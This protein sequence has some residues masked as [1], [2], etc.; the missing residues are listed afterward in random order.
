MAYRIDNH[1]LNTLIIGTV[2]LIPLFNLYSQQENY[3]VEQIPL[4]PE[5]SHISVHCVL[6]DSAGFMWFG[7][8]TGLYRYDGVD[9][10]VF[11]H[12]PYDPMSISSDYIVGIAEEGANTLWVATQEGLDRFDKYAEHFIRIPIGDTL[13]R[14]ML[15]DRKGNI[16]L[17]LA[18][19][20]LIKF[21]KKSEHITRLKY[22]PPHLD[23]VKPSGGLRKLFM[24]SH[25]QLWFLYESTGLGRFNEETEV[26]EGVDQALPCPLGNIF[27]D[28]RGRIWVTSNC[29]LYLFNRDKEVLEQHIYALEDPDRLKSQRVCSILE[30]KSGNLWISTYDGVYNYNQD[31][32]QLFHMQYPETHSNSLP[33][34]TFFTHLFEDDAGTIW[35]FTR[36]GINKLVKD[37]VNFT[38][39]NP[40]PPAS[41]TV[42]GIYLESNDSIVYGSEESYYAYNRKTGIQKKFNLPWTTKMF[43]D[44]HGVF[45]I[46]SAYG[47]FRRIESDSPIPEYIGY[48]PVPGD[49]SS[50]SGLYINRIFE[51]SEGRLW[52]GSRGGFPCYYD[53]EN[54]C[55]IQLVHNPNS[56]A[57]LTIDACISYETG[58]K[59]L[60]AITEGAFKIIPPFKRVSDHAVM[61][62]DVIEF[63]SPIPTQQDIA[64]FYL[65][66]LDSKGSLWLGDRTMGLFK[67][68]EEGNQVKELI[69]YTTREG[70]PS[71]T[72][73]SIQEDNS[74]NLWIGT[75]NGLSKFDP[76]LE[77]FT[78]YYT[79]NGLPTNQ[80]THS[81]AKN[82]NGELF[83]STIAGM[84]SF[85]PDSIQLNT[86][87]PPIKLTGFRVHNQEIIPTEN[88]I[89][90]RSIVF[91]DDVRLQ[92]NQNTLTINF[93]VLNYIQPER[94]QYKY[95]LEG[96]EKDWIFSGQGN[97]VTY[98]NLKSGNYVFRATGSN[99]DGIWNEEGVS[100]GIVINPP[101]WLTW[102][103][104]IIYGLF[105]TSIIL[106]YRRYLL[107]RA[108]LMAD[109]E[110][111]RVKKEKVQEI[112][113]MRSRFFANISHEFRTP[114]TLIL[115]PIEGML[116]KK[117]KETVI[118]IDQLG[119]I[120][121]NAKRLQHLINQLLDISKLETGKIKMR[122]RKG[123]LLNLSERLYNLSF[124]WLRVKISD[125]NMIWLK[126]PDQYILR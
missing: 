75:S 57:R 107:N 102:W 16:W 64:Q 103:A 97:S 83:F 96:L 98:A 17:G 60:W 122:Y 84:I 5:L 87:I 27:E 126:S 119:T 35:N 116:K 42:R 4:V 30:D 22:I 45:W 50:L 3:R 10:K 81:S 74:G 63:V 21:E 18:A 86:Q 124:P 62:T 92:H 79:Q 118:N 68:T 38:V 14:G 71:N 8:N 36:D 67:L 41:N 105:L 20:G 15:D 31:L 44:S 39:I 19:Y 123:I 109:L 47:L 26:F 59:E 85:H 2:L 73:W 46:G 110:L 53:R 1:L 52:I 104:Y 49:S 111:E 40:D 115:G 9:I 13:I 117:A 93:A 125:M 78:N 55:F 34:V 70:L 6:Q 66:H 80:F 28:R 24:D 121:R 114:L 65:S 94:N 112:D 69:L 33:Y 88:S 76:L 90:K 54:D 56:Q 108:Q 82:A 101:P 11:R 89:L 29:G 120:H 37:H 91:T 32:N 100:L 23:I 77:T 12:D 72:I 58:R 48:Q 61:A 99:N 113:H 106:L 43:K 25:G 51:D 7:S 95:M